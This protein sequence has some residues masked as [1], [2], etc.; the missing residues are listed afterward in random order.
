MEEAEFKNLLGKY[1]EGNCTKEE[2][3]ALET[4]YIKEGNKDHIQD[5]GLNDAKEVIWNRLV[6]R[7][8]TQL[9]EVKKDNKERSLYWKL[10]IA[11]SILIVLTAGFY[12]YRA[13]RN[14]QTF[15]TSSLRTEN[16]LPGGNKAI[17][18]L[19]NGAK[20]V[21]DET[22]NGQLAKN[23]GIQ[24]VKLSD[25]Q[26]LYKMSDRKNSMGSTDYNTIE[27]PLGGQYQIIL[28]DN[29]K[30]WLNAGSSLKYPVVF[31]AKRREVELTGEGYF[32]VSKD[33]QRRFLVKTETE[34][35]EVFGTHFNI[36]AYKN[37]H[38]VKTTLLE[39]SVKVSKKGTEG[40]AFLEPGQQ[41]E[42]SKGKFQIVHVDA[43]EAIAW[44]NGYFVFDND[45]LQTA[46]RKVA[47]WYSVDIEYK[48]ELG[49]VQIGGSVSKFSDI[50]KVLSVLHLTTGLNF[51]VEGRR[52]IVS[53]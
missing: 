43:E 33:K 30:V 14:S 31:N 13:Y 1:L 24:I 19:S 52:L 28:E 10:G 44:K 3:I 32:E 41:S 37:E 11:S 29:T 6:A 35:V 22:H 36:N 45:D 50:N 26:L 42:F 49:D 2:L 51:K 18:T 39:G 4:W 9:S 53:R 40:F 46:L 23:S 8:G 12:S 48:E 7:S 21:L 38:L 25:G 27:T 47:R 17:L 20:V 5:R 34:Q 16:I 15:K